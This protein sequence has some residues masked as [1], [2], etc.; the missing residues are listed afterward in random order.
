LHVPR[1][2][3]DEAGEIEVAPWVPRSTA[4]PANVDHI[5]FLLLPILIFVHRFFLAPLAEGTMRLLQERRVI[6]GVL[7]WLG[8]FPGLRLCH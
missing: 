6:I 8:C 3:D 5:W 2:F 4:H 7:C 1:G